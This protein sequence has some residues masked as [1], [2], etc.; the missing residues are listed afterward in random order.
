MLKRTR[1]VDTQADYL[2]LLTYREGKAYIQVTFAI[3]A[4][5]VAM[6]T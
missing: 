1:S 3:G 4:A 6:V 2:N 5:G